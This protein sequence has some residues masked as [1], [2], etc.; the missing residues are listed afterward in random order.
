MLYDTRTNEYYLN[1]KKFDLNSKH[2]VETNN[3]P[4]SLIKLSAYDAIK[5]LQ[6]TSY[7]LIVP[8]GVIGTGSPDEAQY[9]IALEIGRLLSKLGV[10]VV[11]GGRAGIMEAVCKGMS[12]CNGISIGIL[13]ESTIEKANQYVSIPLSSGIGFARNAVIVSSSFCLIAIGGGEWNYVRNCLWT[14]IW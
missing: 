9:Q 1:N 7:R 11:C 5:N 10:I 3:I 13:P 8:I 12:E 6:K 4:N 14:S 2:W